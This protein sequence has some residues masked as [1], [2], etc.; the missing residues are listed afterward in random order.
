MSESGARSELFKYPPLQ[1]AGLLGRFGGLDLVFFASAVGVLVVGV[2]LL[3]QWGYLIAALVVSLVLA[4]IP[5][6]RPGG[7]GLTA[8]LGPGLGAVRDRLT[9][10]GVY[11]GAVFAPGSLEHRM[12]LPGDL[13]GLRMIAVPTRDGVSRIGLLI[14][15]GKRARTATA[16]MLTF[17]ESMVTSDELTRRNAWTGGSRLCRPGARK[18][19]GCR[20]IS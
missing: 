18:G 15:E 4:L 7:R 20:G 10:R 19:R 9:G 13:A 6:P 2:N 12:D 16:A 5:L 14:D 1:S 8:Y 11:R 3:P 17:G